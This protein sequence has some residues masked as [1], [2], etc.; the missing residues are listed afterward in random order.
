MRERKSE[1]LFL[2]ALL[3]FCSCTQSRERRYDDSS[4]H[5]GIADFTA[6]VEARADS[7][8]STMTL[9]QLAAQLVMPG[10]FSSAD[11]ATLKLV[12]EYAS[13]LQL[14]GLVLLKGTPEGALAVIDK[15][16]KGSAVPPF[17]CI[18]AEWGL[19]MR[20]KGMPEFPHF[21]E[22]SP[23]ATDVVMY[24]YGEELAR[25]CKELGINVV[26]G[27]VADI[28]PSRSSVMWNRSLG[29]NPQRV[30]ELCAAY[31][32][33]LED[34]GVMAVA[35]HFPGHGRPS[36]DSHKTLPRIDG[37]LHSMMITDLLPFR[38]WINRNLSAIMIGHLWMPAIDPVERSAAASQIV[39]DDFLRGEL[40][41]KGLIIT[42]AMTMAGAEAS[43]AGV[44]EALKAGADIVLAPK[45]TPGRIAALVKDV[46]AGVISRKVLEAKCR[47]VLFYKY[48]FAADDAPYINNVPAL[49]STEARSLARRLRGK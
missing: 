47:R 16:K 40:D 12:D 5:I 19:A 45:D 10:V 24:D 18:D 44:T 46:K 20:L 34:G 33:G 13:Q 11:E 35:K 30:A 3:L 1:Y 38:L 42:D 25:E 27:P 43:G 4:P 26:L 8:I 9:E 22:I 21:S 23:R 14:G 49:E 39:M 7:L 41:F 37:S 31:G 36:E 28:S 48:R 29:G 15:M 6:E 2:L 17:I 32:R